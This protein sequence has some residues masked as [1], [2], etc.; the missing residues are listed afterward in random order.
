MPA[1]AKINVIPKAEETK[2]DY[3]QTMAELQ[4]YSIDT[5]DPYGFHGVSATQGFMRGGVKMLPQVKLGHK[6]FPKYG[7][8]ACIWYESI[9]ITITLDP[10]IVLAK[11]IYK[12]KCM[13][14]AVGDHEREHVKI[15]RMMANK[16]SKI[17]GRKVY[18]A[19][20]E[21]G[22]IAGPVS[23]DQAQGMADRMQKV[24]Q[25]IVA[26]EFKKMDLE[27][28]EKQ[29]DFDNLGEYESVSA[30]CPK[31]E[32]TEEMLTGSKGKKKS[33]NRR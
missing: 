32:Y 30:Q 2:Y 13:R 15:D 17:M 20:A 28:I 16:Y 31:F 11:E 24:V 5:I 9:D 1:P 25:Q 14:K 8:A 19:L 21:R 3:S 7:N 12:D 29:R 4:Q 26:H 23:P 27:R 18:D 10:T 33:K 22:F 6:F